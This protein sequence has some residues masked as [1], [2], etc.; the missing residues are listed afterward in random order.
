MDYELGRRLA[1][2]AAW[3]G[4]YFWLWEHLGEVSITHA[5]SGRDLGMA[6]IFT[7]ALIGAVSIYLSLVATSK[8]LREMLESV[9]ACSLLLMVGVSP[10]WLIATASRN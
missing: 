8:G 3:G 5:S 9:S 10:F 7:V 2:F 1:L 4:V 6:P